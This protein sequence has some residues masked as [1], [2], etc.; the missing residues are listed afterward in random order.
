MLKLAKIGSTTLS[1]YARIDSYSEA[2]SICLG[3]CRNIPIKAAHCTPSVYIELSNRENK[4][5]FRKKND[6]YGQNISKLHEN[7]VTYTDILSSHGL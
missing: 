6:N 3:F 1:V 5:Y 4:R 7:I 2:H